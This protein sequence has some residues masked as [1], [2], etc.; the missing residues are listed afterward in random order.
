MRCMGVKSPEEQA[1]GMILKTRELLV[2]Q[3]SQAANARR[4]HMAELGI[5]A[6]TGMT[7]IAKPV[8]VLRYNQNGRLP[9]S[10]RAALLQIAEQ[11]GEL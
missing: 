7:S 4:A 1:A 10:A 6:A 11:V 5:I 8:A 3:R 9:A 2:C